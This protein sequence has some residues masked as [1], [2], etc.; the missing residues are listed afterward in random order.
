MGDKFG[1]QNKPPDQQWVVVCTY[2]K[3]V[4]GEKQNRGKMEKAENVRDEEDNMFLIVPVR[5]YGK[6]FRAL[7]DSGASRCFI[8]P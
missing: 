1:D 7:V 4:S 6:V 2:R 5:I 8:S 3:P